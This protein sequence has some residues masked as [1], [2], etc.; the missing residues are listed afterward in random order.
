MASAADLIRGNYFVYKNELVHVE[1]KE[2]ITCGTHCHSKLK[3]YVEGV[4]SGRKDVITLSHQ[5]PVETADVMRK[6]ATVI[7][8]S[9][10]Q[11]MDAVSY[12]TKDAEADEEVLKEINEGD[13]V[14]FVDYLGRVKILEKFR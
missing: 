9:P 2:V 8:K 7:S 10:L 6:K 14:I 3:F 5:D 4:F 13:T 1:R 11:I 12:E